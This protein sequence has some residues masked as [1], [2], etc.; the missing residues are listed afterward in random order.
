MTLVLNMSNNSVSERLS[1]GCEVL[2]AQERYKLVGK[3]IEEI[4]LR[5]YSYETGKVYVNIVQNYL[6][7]GKTPREFLLSITD[8]SR[9][10]VRENYFA[11]KFFFENVIDLE[12]DVSGRGGKYNKT[13]IQKIV[14]KAAKMAGIKK[15]VTPHTLRHSFATYLLEGGADIRYIQTLLGH[16]DIKTTLIYTHVTSHDIR[17]LAVLI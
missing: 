6:K 2:S 8:K 17:K 4:K 15:N 11:L 16:K 10:A 12:F 9:S 14:K 1:V 7:S 3:L 13:I 5:K